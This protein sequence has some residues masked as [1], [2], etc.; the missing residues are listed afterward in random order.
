MQSQFL[1]FLK[2][3]KI[4]PK[5]GFK[6]KDHG[7]REEHKHHG[8]ETESKEESKPAIKS[9]EKMTL[10]EE[11]AAAEAE[12]GCEAQRIE[13]RA[14]THPEELSERVQSEEIIKAYPGEPPETEHKKGIAQTHPEEPEE[15][16]HPEKTAE[17][18]SEEPTE[19][20][21]SEKPTEPHA[22]EPPE[23]EHPK[24]GAETHPEEPA[25]SE[26][27]AEPR[28]EKPSETAHQ[29][30]A[31]ETHPE[32]PSENVH[33]KES[34]EN[35]SKKTEAIETE[36]KAE[37]EKSAQAPEGVY[38]HPEK[39]PGGWHESRT[40]TRTEK[41]SNTEEVY[42]SINR[43]GDFRMCRDALFCDG[44][45]SY[46]IPPEPAE[47]QMIRLR[48]RTAR[49]NV[50]TVLLV[51]DSGIYQMERVLTRGV[52]DY[53]EIHWKLG[54]EAFS[55]YFE[56]HCDDEVCYYNRTGV[57]DDIKPHY[58][59]RIVPGFS[60]PNWAKGAVMYQ[61]FVDRFYNGNPENDV[62]DR[63]YIYIGEPVRKVEDWNEMPHAMDVRRFY[64]GDLQGVMEKLDYLQ[65]LGVE[66]IYFNPLLYHRPIISTISRITIISIRILE[67]S[68]R[69]ES[70]RC[71]REQRTIP[72]RSCIRNASEIWK[73]S[74]Q[75]MSCSSAWW[76]K[77]TAGVCG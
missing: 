40:E 25:H 23:T 48:F 35:C 18:H 70:R 21:H 50:S 42:E 1:E 5:N 7:S 39:H 54:T 31:A 2:K 4:W 26:K 33:P 62:K 8:A 71:P 56:I 77:S 15:A 61:I 66:V 16:A 72:R 19:A 53:Y 30:E 6:K 75:A 45:S 74:K 60:T 34:T 20:A 47:G 41:E 58:S 13:G 46:V 3:R 29:E 24:G 65:D 69:T 57:S 12:S 28:Q 44:T 38:K 52:F 76:K 14:E 9:E 43:K 55:Y 36:A 68:F 51:A 63:E 73:I 22:E 32:E 49:N 17:T 67:S 59:F 64:G 27:P 11:N 10:P 37:P